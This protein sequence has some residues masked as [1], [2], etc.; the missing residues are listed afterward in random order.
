MT[1]TVSVATEILFEH[2]T[3][4]EGEMQR[5]VLKMVK[6]NVCLARWDGDT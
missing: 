5:S 1:V 6:E 2:L 4:C 3:S